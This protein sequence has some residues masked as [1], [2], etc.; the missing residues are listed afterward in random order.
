MTKL[1]N[2][3]NRRNFIRN[4]SYSALGVSLGLPASSASNQNPSISNNLKEPHKTYRIKD[5]LMLQPGLSYFNTGSLGPTPQI[6]LNTVNEVTQLLEQNPVE[7]NW[8]KL[9]RTAD[10][11]RN[12]IADY[13]NANREEILLTRNTTEGMNL[14]AGGLQL[15]PGDEIVT[16]T[17]EHYGGLAGWKFLEKYHGVK[18]V[19]IEFP[20][21]NITPELIIEK[22]KKS[23]TSRTRVCSF[24]DISTVTG[25][26]MPLRQIADLVTPRNILL[27]CDGAQSAGMQKVD[28]AEMGVDVFATSGHKWLLGPKE[29]GFL[30]IRKEIQEQIRSIQLE[31]GFRVYN[32]NTGTRNIANIIGLGKAIEMQQNWGGIAQVQQDILSL[33]NDLKTHLKSL[34]GLTVISPEDPTLQSGI[35]SVILEDHD[36]KKIYKELKLRDIIVKKLAKQNILRFSTHIFNTQDELE[37]LVKTLQILLKQ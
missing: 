29:T 13:I 5:H 14:I 27:V 24:M 18:V 9:G 25:L 11:V 31:T 17:D 1:K 22:I 10:N 16:S 2:K 36:V 28:V 35:T 37:H 33:S 30:Y 6:V 15:K 20:K 21:H 19:N 7:N 23:L 34:P 8:G 3:L 32:H 12:L 26:R 4:I